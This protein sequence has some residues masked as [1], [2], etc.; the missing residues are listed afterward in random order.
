MNSIVYST[1]SD[2]LWNSLSIFMMSA[3]II[4]IALV[5][6]YWFIIFKNIKVPKPFVR[7]TISSEIP[8]QN[9]AQ[10]YFIDKGNSSLIVEISVKQY[11]TLRHINYK[12]SVF[13]IN[14]IGIAD[15]SDGIRLT[16]MDLDFILGRAYLANLRISSEKNY[17]VY[18]WVGYILPGFLLWSYIISF[19]GGVIFL[20]YY[21]QASSQQQEGSF[22]SAIYNFKLYSTIPLLFYGVYIILIV[23]NP[24]VKEGLENDYDTEM[25]KYVKE[26]YLDLYNDFIDARHFS[27]SIKCTY[28][29]GVGFLFNNK[30]LGPFAK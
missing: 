27:R 15:V 14:L 28:H 5:L 4:L 13:Y 20:T 7:K 9:V 8:F 2:N 19:I 23:L 22:L 17:W 12:K 16:G 18:F 26:H 11:S 30:Y 3:G 10:K 24:K 6:V 25:P 21:N 1:T 29:L